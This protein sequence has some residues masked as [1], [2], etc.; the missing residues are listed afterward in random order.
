MG[1][2]ECMEI[3]LPIDSQNKRPHE[4]T[5]QQLP[6]VG[7]F[8]RLF[9]SATWLHY[10]VKSLFYLFPSTFFLPVTR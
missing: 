8:N 10:D 9:V 1:W 4:M 3:K 7:A 6:Q 5:Y 2:V